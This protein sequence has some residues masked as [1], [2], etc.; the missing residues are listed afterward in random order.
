MSGL[1]VYLAFRPF[2]DENAQS[3]PTRPTP[4]AKV[5]IYIWKQM[6]F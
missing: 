4:T 3:N 6:V 2:V 5:S 1:H